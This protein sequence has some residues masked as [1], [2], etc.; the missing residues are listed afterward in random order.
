M[1]SFF[2]IIIIVCAKYLFFVSVIIASL[3]FLASTKSNKK[4]M[5][6]IGLI[7]G[8]ISLVLL[9]ISAMIFNDP[10]PFVVDHIVPLIPHA[11]D[12]GF[13]SD[14]T[15]LTMWL[16]VVLFL[17]DKRLGMLLVLISLIVGIT[18]VLTLIHHPIDI[19]GSI[20]I[21]IVSVVVTKVIFNKAHKTVHR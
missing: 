11:A 16:A 17:F 10:R 9:K 13:P 20:G 21:A 18:R 6:Y 3:Y 7:S 19:L 1:N 2:I 12:N 4:K 15:L 14:H 8:I 5:F